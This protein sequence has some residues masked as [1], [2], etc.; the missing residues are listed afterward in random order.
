MNCKRIFSV[1]RCLLD[2]SFSHLKI[3][4]T[5]SHTQYVS[6]MYLASIVSQSEINLS[7]VK[8][9]SVFSLRTST[10]QI[11]SLQR[12]WAQ[13]PRVLNGEKYNFV[14]RNKLKKKKINKF[15]GQIVFYIRLSE[16]GI[17]YKQICWS[18]CVFKYRWSI[19]SLINSRS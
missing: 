9:R 2:P 15:V 5:L 14:R 3:S 19:L 10:P 4:L 8:K 6:I 17:N 1:R 12:L 16:S 13:V 18:N 7:I 11:N